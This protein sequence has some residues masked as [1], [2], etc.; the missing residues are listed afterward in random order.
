MR[1]D[2]SRQ[3]FRHDLHAV[4]LVHQQGRV[5]LDGDWNENVFHRMDIDEREMVDVIGRCG[6]PDDPTTTEDDAYFLVEADP[7]LGLGDFRI[8]AGRAYVDGRLAMLDEDTT[9][10]TQPDLPN[11][12]PIAAEVQS[13]GQEGLV[14]LEVWQRLVTYLEDESVR[15][16]ALGGPDTVARLRTIAQIK[17]LTFPANGEPQVTCDTAHEL[18]PK[19]GSGTLSTDQP[20]DEDPEDPC[21][22]PDD[23]LYTGRENRLYRVEIHDPGD[24]EGLISPLAGE[25]RWF[26]RAVSGSPAAGETTLTLDATSA[27]SP[28]QVAAVIEA[29]VACLSDDDGNIETLVVSA[30]DGTT[31]TLATPLAGSYEAAKHPVVRGGV[32]RFKWSRDNASFAVRVTAVDA[33]RTILNVASLGR[34]QV[35]ALRAGDLV[36]I[37]DDTSELGPARGFLTYLADNPNPDLF[38]VELQTKLP[39]DFD[40]A[41]LAERHLMLRR[42]DG[43]GWAGDSFDDLDMD[44]G[45]GVRIKFEGADLRAGD[46]WYIRTRKVD[47]SVERRTATPPDGIER[48]RCVLALLR[49]EQ[50]RDLNRD[51]IDLLAVDAGFSEA[52]RQKLQSALPPEPDVFTQDQI[53]QAAAESGASDDQLTALS[54]LLAEKF[55]IILT[56]TDCRQRFPPL[57]QLPVGERHGPY[58]VLK[59]VGGD[60]Q[61]G[62]PGRVLPCPL[63][64]GVEDER[65]RPV[66]NVR[67]TFRVAP[68]SSATLAENPGGPFTAAVTVPSG[69]V[70]GEFGLSRAFVRLGEEPECSQLTARIVEPVPPQDNALPVIFETQTV[71]DVVPPVE[72]FPHV[73]EISWPHDRPMKLSEFNEAGLVVVFDEPMLPQTASL[74]TFVVRIE[75]P[76]I[77]LLNNEPHLAGHRSFIVFGGVDPSGENVWR[78]KPCPV[79]RPEVLD[80]WFSQEREGPLRQAEATGCLQDTTFDP[81]DFELNPIRVRVTLKGD[82]I[83]SKE[84]ERPLDGNVFGRLAQDGRTDLILPSGDGTR[85]GNFES[86][87]F[88]NRESL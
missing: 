77:I 48:H 14:Y 24:V 68:G 88:F 22:L 37:A 6:I 65:G 62:P 32:A 7:A 21:R 12:E 31:L 76:E 35:T 27:L 5:W 8:R 25:E 51:E 67:V 64:V 58:L 72:A 73:V 85:G 39:P 40:V 45:D 38:T 52:A 78:F 57:T 79:W 50:P 34:D 4:G 69:P 2:F 81:R 63:I 46:W 59:L 13:T 47:G 20:D 17:L 23:V 41:K 33:T 74:S 19:P 18:L 70:D 75:I 30:F 80:F 71:R 66:S 42:W 55:K 86:W 83:L 16:S 15:E 9:Y 60:G 61:A 54:G 43:V 36:E 53:N 49:W 28:T 11:P 56:A 44:I 26:A 29:G 1:G 10:L 84:G 87:F 82:A 3:P